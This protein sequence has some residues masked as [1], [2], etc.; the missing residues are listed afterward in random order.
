MPITPYGKSLPNYHRQEN[1]NG[2]NARVV[3]PVGL[4][5]FLLQNQASQAPI[6][7]SHNCLTKT[8]LNQEHSIVIM[9]GRQK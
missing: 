6:P 5:V 7:K 8:I 4:M 3:C 9:P 2:L 1:E